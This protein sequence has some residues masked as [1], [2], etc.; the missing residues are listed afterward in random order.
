MTDRAK[1][2]L[3]LTV[4]ELHAHFECAAHG[5]EAVASAIHHSSFEERILL[6]C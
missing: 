1:R 6:E 5:I 2:E 3:D 4:L